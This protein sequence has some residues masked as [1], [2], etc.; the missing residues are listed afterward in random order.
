[1]NLTTE[2]WMPIVWADGKPG[3][4]S[5]CQV[6]ERG[7]NIRD[8]AVRP[9]ERIA[10]MRLLLCVAQAALDGPADKD[11]WKTCRSKIAPAALDYLKRWHQSFELLGNGPRFLQVEG[12]KKPAGK[13][14]DEEGN[15]VSKLDLALA[16]GNNST[17]FD[18]GGGAERE[19]NTAR[20]ALGAL[21]FQCFSPGGRIGVA[22]WHKTPTPGKGSSDHAP[23]IVGS[24]L[25]AVVRGENLLDTTHL[26]LMTK[27]QVGR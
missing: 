25:H 2:P 3:T 12:L 1:M 27:D 26:N 23:C 17:L 13:D 9:H 21:T 16:T 8:L 20:L 19:F 7:E 15:S 22:E 24:M 5:L 10:V 4:V 18:N 11:D 14:D 6:F